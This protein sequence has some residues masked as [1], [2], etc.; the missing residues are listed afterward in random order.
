M[1]VKFTNILWFHIKECYGIDH[2]SYPVLVKIQAGAPSPARVLSNYL[3]LPNG[4]R[5]ILSI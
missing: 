5:L 3:R 2:V 4:Q 1:L